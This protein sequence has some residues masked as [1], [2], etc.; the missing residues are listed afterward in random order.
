MWRT[1]GLS[2]PL[3]INSGDFLQIEIYYNKRK[4]FWA[5]KREKKSLFLIGMKEN[6]LFMKGEISFLWKEKFPFLYG[7]QNPRPKRNLFSWI[8]NSWIQNYGCSSTRSSRESFPEVKAS[9]SSLLLKKYFTRAPNHEDFLL[10]REKKS[11]FLK[12]KLFLYRE[13]N[14]L[15]L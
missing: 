1:F 5:S 15:L 13:Q 3:F 12:E 6:F 8:Q 11:S 2:A 4:F 14:F 9:E 7:F 10:Y